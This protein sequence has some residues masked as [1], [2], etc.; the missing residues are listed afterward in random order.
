MPIYEQAY[1][2]WQA[3]GPLRRVRSW[4]ITREGLR[5]ILSRR[6]FLGL[7][8]VSWTPFV[9][10]VGRIYIAA[11]FPQAAQLMP[12]GAAIFPELLGWQLAF[13]TLLSIFGGA[14]LVAND[15][16][17]GAIVVYLSRPLT[18][19]DYVFGKLGVLLGLNL[20]VTLLPGLLLYFSA[21]SLLPARFLKWELWWIGPAIVAHSLLISTAMGLLTLAVSSLSRNARVAGV[22]L[23]A[24]WLGLEVMRI[25]ATAAFGRPEI[26]LLS[27][28]ADVRAIGQALFEVSVRGGALHWAWPLLALALVSLG[29]LAILRS[30]VKTV[31]VVQ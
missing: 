25:V 29:C 21:L 17:T 10:E 11:T 16:R 1:R 12:A 20:A 14:G 4:P 27:L 22:A 13:A 6:V 7:L 15:L 18:R 28:Q 5:L 24:L 2:R 23:M 19:R 3:R 31:E 26:S 9:I 8:A 30:R